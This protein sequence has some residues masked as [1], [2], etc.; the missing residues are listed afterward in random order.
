MLEEDEPLLLKRAKECKEARE[1]NRYLALH[2]VSVGKEVSLVAEIFCVD[3]DSIYNWIKKWREEKNLSDKS[4]SGKPP[5]FKE[6][7]K[8]D[9]KGLVEENDPQKYGFNVSFWDCAELRKY[10]LQRGKSVSQETIR[11]IL[12]KIGAHYVKAQFEYQEADTDRQRAFALSFLEDAKN[13]TDD[14]A[15]LFEDEM[16][17]NTKP[18]KG[19]GWTFGDRLI[20]RT[21]ES[22]REHLNTFGA[23]NPID[24]KQMQM[25]S[26]IAKA[27]ALIMFMRKV[28]RTYRKKR[29]I[30]IYLDNGPV[31]KSKLFKEWLGY[32]PK[33]KVRW[34]PPYSPT[35]NP[36]EF[37][38]G[39]DRKKFLN[40]YVFADGSQLWKRFDQ[41]VRRLKPDVVKSVAS[42]IP[43]EALLSFQV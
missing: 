37:V 17:T 39:Y 12:I 7:E 14:I 15:M 43:I 31:H 41:F 28:L 8:K 34:L 32:N 2:A 30:W 13:L 16:S 42:L 24:G 36:Q 20:V 9:L 21:R 1:Q 6:D 11:R 5:A 3:E 40:N 35:L 29:E 18:H 26:H 33:V 25:S 23:T 27:P 4:R 19:Y 38:W 10:Y 22:K